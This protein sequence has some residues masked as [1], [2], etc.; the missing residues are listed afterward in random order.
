MD[1][2]KLLEMK[3]VQAAAAAGLADYALGVTG[4]PLLV[5]LATWIAVHVFIEMPEM[6]SKRAIVEIQRKPREL[7]RRFLMRSGI[8]ARRR[9]LF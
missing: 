5:S 8:H 4:R 1:L 2:S 7:K 3:S 9:E 6:E